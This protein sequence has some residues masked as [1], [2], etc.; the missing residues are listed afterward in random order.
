M[1]PEEVP[2][3]PENFQR[4]IQMAQGHNKKC[5]TS[6]TIRDMQSETNITSHLPEW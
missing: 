6:L 2:K 4:S 5:S 3:E 1:E